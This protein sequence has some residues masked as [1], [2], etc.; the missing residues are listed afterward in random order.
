MLREDN[1]DVRLLAVG[2]ELGLIDDA[3]W[4]AH[5]ERMEA[6]AGATAALEALHLTPRAET[7]AKVE[8]AGWGPLTKAVGGPEWLRRQDVRYLD[9]VTAFELPALEPEVAEA[10]EIE[11]KYAGYIERARRR[12]DALVRW[13]A[14]GRWAQFTTARYD[15]EV[16]DGDHWFPN[17]DGPF[18]A[19]FSRHLRRCWQPNATW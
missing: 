10:F 16:F 8:A 11:V 9:M 5:E 19:T 3:T 4:A 2:R 17:E 7:L 18:R 6:R 13:Q 15:D 14:L 12:A 1:A